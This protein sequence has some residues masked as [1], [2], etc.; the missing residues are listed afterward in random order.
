MK[1]GQEVSAEVRC[2]STSRLASREIL[3]G[4]GVLSGLDS[5]IVEH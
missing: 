2:E 5:A 1:A 4:E 3:G